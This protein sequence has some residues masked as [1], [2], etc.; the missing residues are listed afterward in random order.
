MAKKISLTALLFVFIFF[1]LS[2]TALAAN[3]VEWI[4][5][6][7]ATKL[8]W[9]DAVT[10]EGY[11]IKAED[12]SNDT[13]FVSISKD[14]EKLKSSPLSTG[15]D[16]VYDDK[17]K[18]CAKNVDPNYE[19]ITKGEKEFKT[20]NWN[21]YAELSIEVSSLVT[22]EPN[23][24]IIVETNKD[25]YDSKS[26]VDSR[27]D[28]SINAKNSGEAKA[29][30]VVLTVD[31]AG[32]ELL[33]GRT[34]YTD[35]EISKDETFKPINLTLKAPT[36]WEE[37]NFN[38]TAKINC[39]GVNGKEYE[40]LGSKNITIEKKWD[41]IVSKSFSNDCRMGETVHVSVSVRN[42]GICDITEVLP[43]PLKFLYF[44]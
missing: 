15:M 9:G 22:G 34:K 17:I 13:V 29:R 25:I 21:P 10:V 44:Q 2:M 43:F 39:V 24:D 4:E 31:T 18:V 28:V 3:D 33:K 42:K 7:S 41:L 35:T 12:F 5:K 32:M 27:I 36:P 20:K 26:A 23:F 6:Q 16:V 40:Y 1:S 14:G 30:D 19:T 37:T 11:T 38:I 8:Y